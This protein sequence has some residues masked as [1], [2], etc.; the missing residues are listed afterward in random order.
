VIVCENEG[1]D[2][3][4]FRP[5]GRHKTLNRKDGQQGYSREAIWTN[6]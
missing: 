1:A 5:H 2:W 3:L 6:D 4:P